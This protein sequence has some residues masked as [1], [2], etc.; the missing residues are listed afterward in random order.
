MVISMHTVPGLWKLSGFS[1]SQ[2]KNLDRFYATRFVTRH[3][4][5]LPRPILHY[6]IKVT[7]VYPPQYIP[8]VGYSLIASIVDC[9]D[10]SDIHQGKEK[11]RKPGF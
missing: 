6:A 1:P 5:C 8:R 7:P 2:I 3:V 10:D 11:S 9:E 4:T